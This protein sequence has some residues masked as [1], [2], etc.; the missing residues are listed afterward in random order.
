MNEKHPFDGILFDLDGTLIDTIPLIVETFRYTF[1][2][3]QI[4][5][6]SEEHI[7]AGIGTPLEAYFRLFP[8]VD[9]KELLT[10]YT[11][12]NALGLE[13]G[14]AIFLG[15]PALLN[16]LRSLGIPVGIVTAKRRASAMNTLGVF[17]LENG[18]DAIIAK[19]DTEKHKP[20]PEP[21]LL[22]MKALGLKD[23]ARVL[24]VGDSIHDIQS[25]HAAG[26]AACAVGWS[27]MPHGDLRAQNP[28][29]WADHAMEILDIVTGGLVT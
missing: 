3:H 10:T 6:V 12:F 28:R 29:F 13:K 7:L 23:P 9:T 18:F 24:Y 8:Q 5:G 27:R 17:G 4:D 19:E 11:R 26:C 14:T 25:A 16:A 1:A 22:G 2:K 15:I 21:I 20:H